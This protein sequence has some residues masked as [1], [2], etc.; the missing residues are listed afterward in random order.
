[1]FLRGAKYF[2]K[3]SGFLTAGVAVNEVVWMFLLE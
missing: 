2:D 1:M 3:H